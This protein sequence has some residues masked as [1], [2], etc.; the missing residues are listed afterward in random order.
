[1]K[2]TSI[3][4]CLKGV[5]I[6]LAVCGVLVYALI[7]PE[8]GNSLKLQYPEFSHWYYPWLV[9][10]RLTVIPCYLVL[11]S[12]W[13]VVV[14]I[15]KGRSFSYENGKCFKRISQYVCADSVFFLAGN[16][17]LWLFGINHPGIVIVSM[18]IVFL[19]L[20]ISLASKALSQL[21]DDAAGL[22]EECDLTI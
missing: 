7:L 1:M 3:E 6:G 8:L 17:L 12:A 20:S 2:L 21:V 11:V 10:L 14:N 22:Q 16:I 9:F 4:H 5:I 13:K 19:G 18:V 15:G